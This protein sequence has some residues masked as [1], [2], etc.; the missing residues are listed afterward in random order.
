MR[1]ST[2]PPRSRVPESRAVPSAIPEFLSPK[3]LS[4]RTDISARTLKEW[5]TTGKGPRF[6]R[7]GRQVR[8]ATQDVTDWLAGCHD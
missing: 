6:F 3:T 5:R 7:L 8:Y 2:R 1:S 4:A